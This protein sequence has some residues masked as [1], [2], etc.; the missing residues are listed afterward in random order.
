MGLPI[1]A[2]KARINEYLRMVLQGKA[3]MTVP[4]MIH[5]LRV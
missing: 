5:T 3:N 4:P 1:E 2:R